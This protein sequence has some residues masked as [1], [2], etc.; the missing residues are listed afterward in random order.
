M[1]FLSLIVL[2]LCLVS[3]L[4]ESTNDD[5]GQNVPFNEDYKIR[6]SLNWQNPEFAVPANAHVTALVGMIHSADVGLWNPG[7]KA[8]K[9]L[10]DVAEEGN[11]ISINLE[12]DSFIAANKAL[13]K[14]MFPA[15]PITGD[16]DTILNFNQ[17]FS[18]ISLASMIAPSPDWFMGL[19]DVNLFQNNRWINDT[20]V[21]LI[22]YDAGTE[23]GDT[24]GYANPET[25]PRQNISLLTPVN[26]MVLANGNPAISAI[27]TARFLK[28]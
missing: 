14:F 10:E 20:T 2:A 7:N 15:P 6:I 13:S 18:C 3:C 21:S 28:D 5:T 26:A 19:H 23:D 9:G 11:N 27:G 17:N 4:K 16:L 12:L 24:F 1:K 8:T 22:L 25:I